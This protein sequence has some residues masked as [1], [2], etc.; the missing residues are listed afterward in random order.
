MRLGVGFKY[1]GDCIVNRMKL[2]RSIWQSCSTIVGMA[3]DERNFERD[4]E[5]N[6]IG[7][8]SV[9]KCGVW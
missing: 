7:S 2:T 3:T 8:D 1:H 6:G 9:L 5:V 4:G